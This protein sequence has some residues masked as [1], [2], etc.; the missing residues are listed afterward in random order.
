MYPRGFGTATLAESLRSSRGIADESCR[1]PDAR[2]ATAATG[3]SS[4]SAIGAT[5]S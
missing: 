4:T 2:S 1:D 3:S 5:V